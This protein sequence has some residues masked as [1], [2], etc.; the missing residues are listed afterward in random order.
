MSGMNTWKDLRDFKSSKCKER[1]EF[2]FEIALWHL[3]SKIL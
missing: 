1:T 3:T 2:H